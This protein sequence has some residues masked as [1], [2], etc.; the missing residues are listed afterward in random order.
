M[1]KILL[2]KT[3]KVVII[4]SVEW[5]AWSFPATERSCPMNK[6]VRLALIACLLTFA[7]ALV[8]AAMFAG[9]S[10]RANAQRLAAHTDYTC[11]V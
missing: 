5:P 2:N 3:L 4:V 8:M 1:T 9:Q 7:A 6:T 11:N 10:A